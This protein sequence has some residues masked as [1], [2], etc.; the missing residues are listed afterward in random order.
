MRQAR[1]ETEEKLDQ[2]VRL[3]VVY[4]GYRPI[5]EALGLL[6]QSFPN[7]MVRRSTWSIVEVMQAQNISPSLFQEYW[8]G[9]S[10]RACIVRLRMV[11]RVARILQS[12]R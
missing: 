3:A 10:V 8:Q 5:S 9:N 7:T 1:G 4:G 11:K 6:S 12:K 2:A